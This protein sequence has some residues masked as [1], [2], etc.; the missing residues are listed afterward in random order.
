[1]CTE[2]L[3]AEMSNWHNQLICAGQQCVFPGAEPS[4]HA[5][6]NYG[7]LKTASNPAIK[8]ENFKV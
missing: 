7:K 8:V 1:M 5:N 2:V 4:S 3:F 6:F